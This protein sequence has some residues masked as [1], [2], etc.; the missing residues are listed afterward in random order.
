[1]N[2]CN[3]SSDLSEGIQCLWR[4][5]ETL[6]FVEDV[7]E[8]RLERGITFDFGCQ[9]LDFARQ[10][11]LLLFHRD[12]LLFF[13]I[14]K[15]SAFRPAGGERSVAVFQC[16]HGTREFFRSVDHARVFGFCEIPGRRQ[17]GH[18]DLCVEEAFKKFLVLGFETGI[19]LVQ[20]AADFFQA[21]IERF[22]V[23][24]GLI[25]FLACGTRRFDGGRQCHLGVGEELSCRLLAN[26][27]VG[28]LIGRGRCGGLDRVESQG[29]RPH[30]K[31]G[32][33]NCDGAIF[34]RGG[35]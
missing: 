34:H 9:L 27:F 21:L 30:D 1:M 25:E 16:R 5:R 29:D 13:F 7:L 3:E 10:G 24:V 35:L 18:G 6:G 28:R 14:R 26:W 33:K 31:R 4:A 17:F 32:H 15:F 23:R 11:R 19:G 2:A 12:K 20:R 22:G 8:A